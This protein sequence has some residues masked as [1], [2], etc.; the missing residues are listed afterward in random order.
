VTDSRPRRVSAVLLAFLLPPLTA[1]SLGAETDWGGDV[2]LFPFLFLEEVPLTRSDVELMV[3]RGKLTADLSSDFRFEAH[4]VLE[5]SSPPLASPSTSVVAGETRRY[6]D[7]DHTVIDEADLLGVASLD[8][9][10]L[11]WDRP[12]F[13]L[14]TG[15]QAVTWGVSY[16]WPVIDLFAPFAP[17]RVDRDY[18]PGVDAARLVV[19][20]GNFSEI[21]L[22]GAVQGDDPSEDSSVASLGRFHAGRTDFGY[23]LGQFH[24]D[25][26]A[27]F[28]VA[29]EAAG[30]A[31]RLEVAHTES[32]EVSFL[33]DE[34]ESF[35]RASV[36]ADRQL[37]PQVF[38]S[39]EAHWNG[40]GSDDPE[41]YVRL[42]QSDR[43]R[44]G[45]VTSLGRAYS[46]VSLAWQVHPL[47]TVSAALLTNWTDGSSLLQPGF[48]WSLSNNSTLL[49]G[50]IV[51]IGPGTD[52]PDEGA[53][54]QAEP[55]S[56]ESE[57]GLSPLTLWAS[58]KLFF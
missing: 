13:R 2:R 48:T 6:F 5:L 28:F 25:D 40:F 51:G 38:L 7:L 34:K 56:I 46:G 22:I 53:D 8:R 4:A 52:L 55:I 50:L 32:D 10:N 14:T 42:A 12:S 29:S 45:E 58:Y 36:G 37:S 27:G 9:L 39:A 15:R 19:P 20:L 17:Q 30:T 26:V 21:E 35:W 47:G 31:L 23:M 41:D 11:R 18:K 16:F 49:V 54:S 43:V 24:G 1:P 3:L 33:D 57:Y 44:R